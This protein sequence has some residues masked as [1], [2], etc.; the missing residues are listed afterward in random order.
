MNELLEGKDNYSDVR[1]TLDYED[2]LDVIKQISKHVDPM[3]A[4]IPDIVDIYRAKNY[5]SI[6]GYHDPKA[7]WK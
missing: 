4:S 5:A 2:D 7:G 6:N 3:R 1:I